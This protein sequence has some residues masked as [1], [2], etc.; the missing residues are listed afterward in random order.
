MEKKKKKLTDQQKLFL[1]ELYGDEA[2]GDVKVAMRLAGYSENCRPSQILKSLGMEVKS[3][4][5]DALAAMAGKA[6]FSVQSVMENP[7][8][9]GSAMKLKAAESVLDRSG[10]KENPSDVN[11]NVPS[12]GLVILPAKKEHTEDVDDETK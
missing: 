3:S 2:R 12:G 10:I 4:A 9:A 6:V 11:L 7:D 8:Q 5:K 1:E